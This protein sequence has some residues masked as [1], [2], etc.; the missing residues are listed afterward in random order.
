MLKR[1]SI[2]PKLLNPKLS[3]RKSSVMCY[4]TCYV[5]DHTERFRT[6]SLS[7]RSES[8]QRRT[9][10]SQSLANWRSNPIAVQCGRMK[11]YTVNAMPGLRPRSGTRPFAKEQKGTLPLQSEKCLFFEFSSVLNDDA[12]PVS[13]ESSCSLTVCE[14]HMII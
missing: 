7:L 14:L 1:H 4:S 3:F 5:R 9:D 8:I 12:E 10:R 6:R 13:F 11:D 2:C